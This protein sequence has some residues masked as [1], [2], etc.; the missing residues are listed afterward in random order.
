MVFLLASISH[1]EGLLVEARFE[2]PNDDESTH[3]VLVLTPE[4]PGAKARALEMDVPGSL[5]ADLPAGTWSVG[6]QAEGYWLPPHRFEVEAA[7]TSPKLT[8]DLWRAGKIVGRLETEEKTTPPS[9]LALRVSSR[10]EEKD[11][12]F[13][14]VCP[15]LGD[16]FSCLVPAGT[17]DLRLAA[18]DLIPH[19][20]W[21]LEIPWRNELLL[22]K[23]ALQ[24]GASIIGWVDFFVPPDEDDEAGLDR[25]TASLTSIQG[26]AGS[27]AQRQ[28]LAAMAPKTSVT[29]RG[30][31]QLRGISPGNYRLTLDHP[32]MSATQQNGLLVGGKGEIDVGT[33]E[34]WPTVAL[35]VRVDPP[36]DPYRQPWS[37]SLSRETSNLQYHL[38]T[39]EGS[40]DE[41]GFWR[42]DDLDRG[43]TRL[44]LKDARGSTWS[45]RA[46]VLE[47]DSTHI[48]L[49]GH[50]SRLELALRLGGDEGEPVA[51]AE[52]TLM[53]REYNAQITRTTTEEGSAFFF[54]PL[55]RTW[56]ADAK[57]Y[58]LGFSKRFEDLEVPPRRPEDRM[59]RLVLGLPDTTLEG[60]VV[61][62]D[63]SSITGQATINARSEGR[64]GYGST[65]S[66]GT[67]L[68]R[69]LE[70]GMVQLE[71]ELPLSKEH[72][73][74]SDLQRARLTAGTPADPVVLTLG[75][76][77]HLEGIVLSPGG[78]GVPGSLVLA[79]RISP[80]PSDP[81]LAVPPQ[82]YTDVDGTF[83]LDLPPGM[84]RALLQ[85]F[86][87]G[88]VP[89][90]VEVAREQQEPVIVEV[91]EVGGEVMVHYELP[92]D[93][94]HSGTL[95]DLVRLTL[96][97][98][99]GQR[100][101]NGVLFTS[102]WNPMNGLGP[103][104][105]GSLHITRLQPGD[106]TLCLGGAPNQP[107]TFCT[108][109]YL[110]PHGT[111]EVS[112]PRRALDV[113]TDR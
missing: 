42:V 35:E 11:W 33:L 102:I 26:G 83:S 87:P 29:A 22:G 85:V 49:D 91:E 34:L 111:L 86:P 48:E 84:D 94:A 50:R 38:T 41:Q 2:H 75:T 51:G 53:D 82:T 27:P 79:S 43:A 68:L 30:F 96:L 47:R 95:R 103:S 5:Q 100:V 1:A 31:F 10:E 62:A 36:Y 76:G 64:V 60:R 93:E 56:I 45:S 99:Q 78:L 52:I 61:E 23:L 13:D 63:G 80:D 92:P 66:D 81:Y 25:G 113:L 44:F 8:L 18:E 28:R 104:P 108:E 9:E 109:G 57:H 110:P 73:R 3:L 16:T 39:H 17:I 74:R 59:P 24:S 12:V 20:F 101:G 40:V 4:S 72:R 37:L 106:Y 77:G 58:E 112:I 71:A 89:A 70:P 88:F 15:T 105:P 54:V 107:D 32:A 7:P 19:Y 21:D 46:L 14:L 65:R 97:Y 98:R 90:Q 55:D 6:G 67:F 69:G